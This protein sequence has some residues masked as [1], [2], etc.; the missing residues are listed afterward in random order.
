MTNMKGS[1]GLASCFHGSIMCIEMIICCHWN[2]ASVLFMEQNIN[3][4]SSSLY[5]QTP[6]FVG[7]DVKHCNLNNHSNNFEWME[8]YPQQLHHARSAL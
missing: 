3:R 8:V 7:H 1:P 6:I 4:N 5:M 2:R